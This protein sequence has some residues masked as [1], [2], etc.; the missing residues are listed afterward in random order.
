MHKAV[1]DP[2]K[3]PEGDA[4][5]LLIDQRFTKKQYFPIR[6]RESIKKKK[7]NNAIYIYPLYKT[8]AAEK[9]LCR[10]DD[11]TVSDI[12]AKYHYRVF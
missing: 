3:K 10:P 1:T 7:K 12:K 8:V 9:K 5:A 4:L 6:E 11:F 2:V